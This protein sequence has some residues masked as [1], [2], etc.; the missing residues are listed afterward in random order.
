[1]ARDPSNLV[2]VDLETTGVSVRHRVILEIASVVTDKDLRVVEEG[3]N[4]VIY[5]P[6]EALERIDD[7]CAQQ[8]EI[9]GLLE[10]AKASDISLREAEQKTLAFVRRHT[11]RRS[12]PLCGRSILLDRRFLM[13][14][15]PDLHGHLSHRNLD[16][17]TI[18]ELAARWYPGVLPRVETDHRHRAAQDV[19]ASIE[20]LRAYRRLI[21]KD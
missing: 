12:S 4:L 5:H 8:Y 2:W 13:R 18:S 15:M 10:A 19:L 11:H 3:P 1:M 6:E 9:S 7:W 16:V 20:A 17:G 14:Y 21:F